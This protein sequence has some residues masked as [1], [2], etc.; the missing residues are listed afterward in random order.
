MSFAHIRKLAV[1]TE[2]LKEGKCG[3]DVE[4]ASVVNRKI[5]HAAG[6]FHAIHRTFQTQLACCS[7]GSRLCEN[8]EHDTLCP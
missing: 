6:L 1:L 2:G 8:A 3:G 5:G 4:G 7:F